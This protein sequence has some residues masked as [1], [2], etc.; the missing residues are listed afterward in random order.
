MTGGPAT[1]LLDDVTAVSLALSPPERGFLDCHVEAF[2]VRVRDVGGDVRYV[3]GD[4][5]S[6]G[7]APATETRRGVQDIVCRLHRSGGRERITIGRMTIDVDGTRAVWKFR[8][9]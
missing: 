4:G 3:E 8:D 5:I 7:V 6:L 1:P 9:N 2:D